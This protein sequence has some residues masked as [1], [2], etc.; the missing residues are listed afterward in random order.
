MRFDTVTF[1]NGQGQQLAG[2]ID[3][4]VTGDPIAFAVYAHCF[5]CTKNLRAI[6]RIA[7]TL[8]LHGVATLRF[9]FAGLGG[10]EGEFADTNFSTNVDD[11]IAAA[12][13]LAREHRAPELVI[14]HSLGGAVA[15]VAAATM[16]SIR[17]VV[18]I[19]APASADHITRHIADDLDKIENEGEAEVLLAGRP[20]VIRQQLIEDTR[21]VHLA[22]AITTLRRPLLV[23]HSPTDNTVGVE[24]AA[25]IFGYARHPKSFVALDSVDHLISD[26]R[27]ARYVAELIASWAD[28]YPA[29]DLTA[30]S[31]PD[32]KTDAP[33]SVTIVRT[34]QGFRSDI[35]SN[36]FPL[37]ADEPVSVG[38]TNTGPTPYDYLLVALGSCTSMTLR[39]YAD[40]KEWPLHTVTV[41][42][43]H[44]K[45]H[46]RDC[47]EC[48]T[49]GGIVDH[50]ERE[51]ELSGPLEDEQRERLREIADRCPVHKTLHGEVVGH[52]TLAGGQ[53]PSKE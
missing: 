46:A 43:S 40:K 10:S 26:D 48:E 23:L 16:E 30:H 31:Q 11:L 35:I 7:E 42:L 13:F 8:A 19:A 14:G 32:F 44:R 47:E 37:V 36:G 27:D 52:T 39:M 22:D 38:G 20:F 34:E 41:R 5:T 4:P 45:I 12:A 3:Y 9:D 24:N 51:I 18:T 1:P 50:I 33:E 6:G 2:R 28:R 15:L 21:H 29:G 17:A 25:E 49:E 53:P